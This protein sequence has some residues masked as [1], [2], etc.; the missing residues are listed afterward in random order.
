LWQIAKR[1]FF[2]ILQF[3]NTIYF[4]L[5]TSVFIM[6]AFG[7]HL[8]IG[9]GN[10]SHYIDVSNYLPLIILTLFMLYYVVYFLTILNKVVEEEIRNG[11]QEM[12]LA[13]IKKE[14]YFL[15]MILG[16]VLG[17]AALLIIFQIL[18]Y[19]L[20]LILVGKIEGHPS[21][22]GLLMLNM[23]L[24]IEIFY[25]FRFCFKIKLGDFLSFFIF[26]ILLILSHPFIVKKLGIG[27]LT[28]GGKLIL[29]P[30]FLLQNSGLTLILGF[31]VDFCVVPILNILIYHVVFLLIYLKNIKKYE[32][33]K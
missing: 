27:G 24:L 13:Y 17:G 3:K 32:C 19:L 6:F 11:M 4:I 2:K 9:I 15:G 5:I 30:L 10:K 18:V 7:L 31:N 33:E 29:P 8:K 21:G 20:E 14:K 22:I 12:I 28:Y 16:S 1:S 26:L 23:I 25:I